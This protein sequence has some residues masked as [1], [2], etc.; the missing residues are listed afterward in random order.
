MSCAP[1]L[2]VWRVVGELIREMIVQGFND[3]NDIIRMVLM[4]ILVKTGGCPSGGSNRILCCVPHGSLSPGPRTTHSSS[5]Y[6]HSLEYRSPIHT[7]IIN[8]N[9]DLFFS[10]MR[11]EKIY[12]FIL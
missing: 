5:E 8:E 1:L 3:I 12:I 2:R 11:K 4:R 7:T 6:H 9:S 10:N